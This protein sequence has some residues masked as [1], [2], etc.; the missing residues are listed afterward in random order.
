MD[1][2]FPE[3]WL[4]DRR[5]TKLTDR[6][7]RTF[8]LTLTWSVSNRTDGVIEQD[9]FAV[10][11]GANVDDAKA[12]HA[13]GLW[14]IVPGRPAYKM[15]D[16]AN[17]QTS[18]HE[19]EVLDNARRRDREKKARQRAKK[20]GGPDDTDPSSSPVSP[21]TVPGDGPGG[22]H[23]LGEARRGEDR[24]QLGEGVSDTEV[25]AVDTSTGEV[26]SDGW[27][28]EICDVCNGPMTS[29]SPG[30]TTHPTCT[31]SAPVA[32]QALEDRRRSA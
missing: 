27:P 22:Q 32:Q 25:G 17:T 9:D 29:Y 6:Q 30:Q 4:L 28:A 21:G 16:F 24:Q 7:F 5:F 8:V 11:P 23:R 12:L 19:L 20:A 3:R 13:A 26:L 31:R 2:R 18:S 1:A 15:V 10:I 14:E